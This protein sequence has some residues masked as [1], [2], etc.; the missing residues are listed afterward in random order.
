MDLI[1]KLGTKPPTDKADK[2]IE[3]AVPAVKHSPQAG[4]MISQAKGT[5][6]KKP[7]AEVETKTATEE[8][9]TETVTAA[10]TEDKPSEVADPES[11]TKDSAFKEVKKLREENKAYRIKYEE[12]LESLKG[13]LETQLAVKNQELENLKKSQAELDEIKAK[14]ADKERNLAEKVAHREA[15]AAEWKTKAESI[16]KAYKEQMAAM[17]T[18]LDKHQAD[19]DAQRE[20]YKT[21]LQNELKTIPEKFKEVADLIVRGAGDERDA[22]V[23]ISEAKL[24]GVFEDKTVVV[25]HSVPGASDGARTTNE[26]LADARKAERNKMSSSQ[27]IGEAL[28]QIKGGE[29]NPVFKSNRH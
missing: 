3:T 18:Q 28:K 12:K 6:T 21:R 17:K 27:K 23:A 5:G 19:I 29:A 26:R 10:K 14:E 22:I 11:W 1:N 7:E 15:L 4:D 9:T 2:T 13:E 20:V 25:N 16:E 8:E 24:K